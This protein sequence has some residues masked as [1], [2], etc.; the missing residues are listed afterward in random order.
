MEQP[1]TLLI[2]KCGNNMG[3]MKRLSEQ[4]RES[5]RRKK[6]LLGSREGLPFEISLRSVSETE[7]Y[8]RSQ[9]KERLEQFNDD[10]KGWS[11][12]TTRQL[13][14]NVRL[15]VKKDEKLSQ[16]IEPNIYLK[17]GESERI[18]FS[19]VR[20]GVYIHRGAGNGQGGF[21]GG[22]KWTDKYGKLKQTNPLSFFKMGQG[23]R[24][25]ILWFDPIIQKNLPAL[26]DIVA[27]Y[28]G[29]MQID[30]TQIFI[31]K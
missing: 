4:I 6:S 10:I 16:S 15:L 30:A 29:D 27:E 25:P 12:N 26:A 23:N 13:R 22:S 20:E 19:F 1:A 11:I 7:R 2:L 21:R 3:L 5:K 14:T 17:K 28:A 31:E 24:T 8:Q 9:N 18:G